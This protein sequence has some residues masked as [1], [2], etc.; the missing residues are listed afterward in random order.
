[1]TPNTTHRANNLQNA[2]NEL[3]MA[4][5]RPDV[6]LLEGVIKQY[7]ELATELTE[8]A[9]ELAIDFLV[10]PEVD[11]EVVVNLDEV[12]PLVSRAMSN[13]EN[14]LYKRKQDKAKVEEQS[15]TAPETVTVNPFE[16]MDRKG[17]RAFTFAIHASKIFA[18]KIRDRQIKLATIPIRYLEM[19]AESLRVTL[20][21]LREYLTNNN[22]R[23]TPGI[24]FFKAE[25]KPDHDVQQS[26]DEAVASSG[27]TDEQQ[28]FLLSLK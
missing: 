18:M 1:M 27:L 2:I 7:P 22:G 23:L 25:G 11:H 26:F 19:I 21:Q 16:E 12:S 8:F 5:R 6:D 15:M 3:A 20:D 14:E 24:Q 4:Q 28:Q 13:F 9:I 10:N 17:F